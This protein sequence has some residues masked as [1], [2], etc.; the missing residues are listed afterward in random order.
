VV[1]LTV[2][3]VEQ[4]SIDQIDLVPRVRLDQT[5]E[6]K[7]V[8]QKE[9]LLIILKV[10][11]EVVLKIILKIGRPQH[12]IGPVVAADQEK[13]ECFVQLMV[14]DMVAEAVVLHHQLLLHKEEL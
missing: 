9:L 8:K 3:I 1:Q 11:L 10:L 6:E 12:S 13:Q 2:H 4:H 5:Q 14:E 7:A